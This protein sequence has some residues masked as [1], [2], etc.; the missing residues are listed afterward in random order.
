MKLIDV[1]RRDYIPLSNKGVKVKGTIM[2]E[3]SEQ[4]RKFTIY[5][6]KGYSIDIKGGFVWLNK[7]N[8]EQVLSG[9]AILAIGLLGFVV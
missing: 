4:M 6:W 3:K 9:I 1:D 2:P 8:A 5:R 7:M